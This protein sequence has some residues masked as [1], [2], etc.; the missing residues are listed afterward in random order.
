V[1][2]SRSGWMRPCSSSAAR[3]A[4]S[5]GRPRSWTSPPAVSSMSSR[6]EMRCLRCVG[7]QIVTRRGAPRSGSRRSTCPG[8]TA[9][10]SIALLPDAVQGADPFHLVRLAGEKHGRGPTPGPERDPRPPRSQARSALPGPSAA[11]ARPRTS[12]R[13]C[14]GQADRA[15]A[16]RRSPRGEVATAWHAKVAVRSLYA[17]RDQEL[18]LEWVDQLSEDLRDREC[19]PEVRQL[20]CTMRRWRTQIAAWH[21]A[22]VTNGPTETMN[23]LAKGIKRV[24]FGMTDFVHWRIRAALRRPPELVTAQ[25]R[26]PPMTP[27]ISEAPVWC[28]TPHEA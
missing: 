13:T 24:A 22:Q 26:G 27:L 10:C 11:R 18:A 5:S 12:R 14:R 23:G 28:M 17:H 2:W 7:S 15:T 6:A 25:P 4:P 8:R 19:P 1:T 20:G 21:Q 3:G 16:C 9:R